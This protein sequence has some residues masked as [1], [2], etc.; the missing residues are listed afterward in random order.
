MTPPSLRRSSP[1]GGSTITGVIFDTTTRAKLSDDGVAPMWSSAAFDPSGRL[2]TTWQGV[3]TLR[4][5]RSIAYSAPDDPTYPDA[6]GAE[7]RIR[8]FDAAT[9]TLGAARVLVPRG[10]LGV[11]L[12]GFSPDGQ[13][14]VYSRRQGTAHAGAAVLT[15]DGR[16]AFEISADPHD[17]KARWA[18]TTAPT[19]ADGTVAELGWIV[20]LS[21]R[22]VG[23]RKQDTAP[24]LW[25]VA[26]DLDHHVATRPFHL[27]GQPA[28]LGARYAPV[29]VTRD[30][31]PAAESPRLRLHSPRR[32]RSTI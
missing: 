17:E 6:I 11:E 18:S 4:D 2:V 14:L 20:L 3:M 29:L 23:A 32:T 10:P 21:S 13:W 25:L 1:A 26:V 22:P 24:Q 19:R 15:A 12:P 30:P 28:D 5:G 16:D 9:A 31:E 8:A 27:R 7:I